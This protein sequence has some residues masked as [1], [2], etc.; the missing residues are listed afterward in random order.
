M[1]I[2]ASTAVTFGLRKVLVLLEVALVGGLNVALVGCA[3]KFVR[4]V[5]VVVVP[6]AGS[7]REDQ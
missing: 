4:H 7:D 2:V 5:R 6:A 1:L 3:E